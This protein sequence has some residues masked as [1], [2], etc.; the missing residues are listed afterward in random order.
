M[1]LIDRDALV[2]KIEVCYNECL[3]KAKIIDTDYWN[4]KA[5]AYRN[6][7][8]ILNET[9]FEKQVEQTEIHKGRN[10]RCIKTHKYA[11]VEWRE[12]IKYYAN[13]DFELVNEGCTYYC[14]KYSKEEHN[15]L[16]EEIE[17]KIG[18]VEKQGEQK[19]VNKV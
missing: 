10:Y 19:H 1:N 14:P 5:E 11:G 3:K 13:E 6:L 18:C 8:V 2:A 9:L 17:K 15:K 16:F 12:G 7:L 4:A